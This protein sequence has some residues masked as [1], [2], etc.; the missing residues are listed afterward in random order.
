METSRIAEFPVFADLPAEELDAV[1][2]VMREVA[3]DAGYPI[4]RADDYGTAVYFIE[5]GEVDVTTDGE[6]GRTLGRGEAFGEI[7]MLLTGERT[8]TVTARVPVR[9]LVLSGPDFEQIR[10]RVPELEQSLR[11]VGIERASR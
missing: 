2:G 7:G 4:V 6:G 1:A 8:A 9:L 3:Y 10:S 5:Y 11:R